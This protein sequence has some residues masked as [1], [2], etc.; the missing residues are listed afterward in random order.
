MKCEITA[1]LKN[2]VLEFTLPKA[3]K[4]HTLRIHPKAA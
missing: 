4:A 2:G 3:A 1:T